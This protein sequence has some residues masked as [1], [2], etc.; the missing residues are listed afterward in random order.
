MVEMI[1]GSHSSGLRGECLA[2]DVFIVY[3][4]FSVVMKNADRELV[5]LFWVNV[6]K[7]KVFLSREIYLI[8]QNPY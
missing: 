4:Y 5:Y 6:L 3:P 7:D 8:K 2:S 1:R